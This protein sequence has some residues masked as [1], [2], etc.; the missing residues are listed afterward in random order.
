M[1]SRS[2]EE[3][4]LHGNKATE[5]VT[6]QLDADHP[7]QFQKALVPSSVIS[8]ESD[9]KHSSTNKC[10]KVSPAYLDIELNWLQALDSIL[11][12][13][14]VPWPLCLILTPEVMQRYANVFTGLL[15]YKLVEWWLSRVWW[16]LRETTVASIGRMQ[17]PRKSYERLKTVHIWYMVSVCIL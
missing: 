16:K 14:D 8:Q 5:R 4:S 15:K 1:L 13:Y 12:K 7:L 17:G 3:S 9:L 6:L 2:F 11:L 10:D